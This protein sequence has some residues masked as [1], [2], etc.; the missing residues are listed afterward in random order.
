MVFLK[1]FSHLYAALKGLINYLKAVRLALGLPGPPAHPIIGNAFT[2][3]NSKGE[4]LIQRVLILR[5]K[6]QLNYCKFFIKV[7]GG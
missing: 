4:F 7:Q 3:A 1:W 2:V 6:V 5:E